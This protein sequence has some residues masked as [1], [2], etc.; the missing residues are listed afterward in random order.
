MKEE[1][2]YYAFVKDFNTF[3]HDHTL[4]RG[5]KHVFRYFLQTFRTAQK[6]NCHVKNCFKINGK[7]TIRH[8]RMVNILN[9][10]YLKK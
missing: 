1:K 6:L 3:M 7:K 4:H 10:K 2:K 9:L 5:R 8:L